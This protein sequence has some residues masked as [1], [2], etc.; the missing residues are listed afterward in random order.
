MTLKTRRRASVSLVIWVVFISAALGFQGGASKPR[1]SNGRIQEVASPSPMT[2]P[3]PTPTP[4]PSPSPPNFIWTDPTTWPATL[5]PAVVG[6]FTSLT[7][8][9]IQLAVSIGVGIWGLYRYFDSKKEKRKAEQAEQAL[10][11]VS[12][13]L[14]DRIGYKVGKLEIHIDIV[15]YDG[16]CQTRWIWSDIRKVRPSVS[17]TCFPG[18]MYFL[19]TNSS[20]SKY[21]ALLPGHANKYEIDFLRRDKNHCEFQVK[22]KAG[23]STGRISYEYD[24][25]VKSAFFMNLEDLAGS[26][27]KFEWF[28]FTTITVIDE[29]VIKIFFPPYYRADGLQPDVCMGMVPADVSDTE[30]AERVRDSGFTNEAGEATIRVLKPKIGNL[31]YFRW[32]PLA[33]DLVEAMR[34]NVKTH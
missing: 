24:A 4:S 5:W 21:P 18:K 17:L 14:S 12:E 33:K 9:L 8:A 7:T 25:S 30:E 31:Y 27:Y 20:F 6:F 15:N 10:H 2:T 22:I 23:G 19:T 16:D 13:E 34:R 32:T 3:A 26:H 28:G 11:Q 29:L 1:L